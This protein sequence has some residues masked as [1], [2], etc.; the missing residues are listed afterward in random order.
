MR[1]YSITVTSKNSNII[2]QVLKLC[3]TIDMDER[4]VEMN[5]RDVN[6]DIENRLAQYIAH[7]IPEKALPL[8][9]KEFG[10]TEEALDKCLTGQTGQLVAGEGYVYQS[11]VIRFLQ[12][13]PVID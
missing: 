8:V 2:E 7:G 1:K 9:C 3:D 13:L 5:S 6:D 4:S 12:G 11:D 10:V